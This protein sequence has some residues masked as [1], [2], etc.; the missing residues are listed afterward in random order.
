MVVKTDPCAFTENKIYP[1]RGRK[2]VSKDGK[3][4][5]FVSHK[6]SSLYKQRIKPV[7]L[8]WTAAWRRHHNKG[9][10]QESAK[11]RV[12]KHGRIQKAIVGMTLDEIKRKKEEKPQEREQKREAARKE[13]QDRQKKK[14]DA[15]KQEKAKIQ[16]SKA[17][18]AGKKDAKKAQNA[19]KKR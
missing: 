6:A 1:G 10:S 8:T 18:A 19:G 17:P 15:K 9:K 12:R 7:R 3:V 2:F 5:Y 16:K 13:L 11:R 14:V 4:H